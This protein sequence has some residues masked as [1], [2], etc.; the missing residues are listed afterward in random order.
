MMTIYNGS[1]RS[2]VLDKGVMGKEEWEIVMAGWY[3][4][5]CLVGMSCRNGSR[6]S[7]LHV[8]QYYIL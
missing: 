4:M 2:L 6:C 8:L 1:R 5:L 7:P 3:L